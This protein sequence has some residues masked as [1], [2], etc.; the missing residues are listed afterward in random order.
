MA[1]RLILASL[2]SAGV[3]PAV[4]FYYWGDD[5][6]PRCVENGC[7]DQYQGVQ[8][9][10]ATWTRMSNELAD[11]IVQGIDHKGFA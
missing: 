8:K 7:T 1:G 6:S 10:K 3:T 11:L 4:H 9:D 2:R 5:I